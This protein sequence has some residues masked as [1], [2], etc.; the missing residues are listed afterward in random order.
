M[1]RR[2]AKAPAQDANAPEEP[3]HKRPAP[4]EDL[5]RW[6]Y[7]RGLLSRGEAQN[8]EWVHSLHYRAHGSGYAAVNLDAFHGVSSYAD[9]WR[10]TWT[11]AESLS[12]LCQL[13]ASM[14]F[15]AWFVLERVT[16][17]GEWAKQAARRL[18]V[19]E[20]RGMGLLREALQAVDRYRATVAGGRTAQF[21]TAI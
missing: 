20:R 16:F 3:A 6:Y 17:Y 12:A 11:Q 1:K 21:E 2:K 7:L 4:P 8:A 9:N 15:E 10:F 13:Q 18:G 14:P 19:S 5:M